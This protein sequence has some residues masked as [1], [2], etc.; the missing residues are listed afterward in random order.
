MKSKKVVDTFSARGLG[1]VRLDGSGLRSGALCVVAGR[2][3]TLALGSGVL[4]EAGDA[5]QTRASGVGGVGGVRDEALGGD[6][7]ELETGLSEPMALTMTWM[8]LSA[9]V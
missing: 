3:V 6:V 9:L 1:V 2:E 5:V 8:I 7:G 4:K